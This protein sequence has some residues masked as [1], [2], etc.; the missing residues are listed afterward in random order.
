VEGAFDHSQV[1]RAI[2]K[3]EA[4]QILHEAEEAGLVH[5]TGN[6]VERHYYVCNCC[7]CSCGILRGVAE[8]GVPTAVAKADFRAAVE[9][10][11][12]IGCGD[13]VERCQFEALSVPGEI[14]AVDEVRCVGCGVCATVCPTDALHLERR[15][16]GELRVPPADVKEWGRRRAEARGISLAQVL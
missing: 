5:S 2:T 6:Y 7:T 13:C 16:K 15:P 14:C 4:L 3:E 9:A 8:F 1:D 10:E 11:V 12:C